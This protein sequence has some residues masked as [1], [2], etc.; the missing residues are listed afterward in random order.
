[1][2]A[3]PKPAGMSR[4]EFLR[5]GAFLA[6]GA[7][8]GAAVATGATW[9]ALGS[10][11]LPMAQDAPS[12]ILSSNG[13]KRPLAPLLVDDLAGAPVVVNTSLWQDAPA[14]VYKVAKNVLAASSRVRGYNTGQFAIQHP[15]E[16]DSALLAYDGRCTHL[17]CTVGW[18]AQLGASKDIAD[19][20]GDG[21]PDGRILCPCHQSQFD[22]FDL[23]KNVPGVPA[24]RPLSV[25]RIAIRPL[26]DASSGPAPENALWGL[27]RIRQD[28]YRA[29]DRQGVG[30][31]FA[32]AG[33]S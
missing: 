32:L 33:Q 16:P 11:R 28:T 2:D 15:T 25:L 14:V 31:G 13:G 27:E 23:A 6:G 3:P 12:L 22:I 30:R 7:L 19:Y 20:D 21:V 29:A 17:N 5:D 10:Q 4:R 1:M 24:R 9:A 8:V 18:N 26:A